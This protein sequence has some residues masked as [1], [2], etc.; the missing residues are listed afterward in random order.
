MHASI[1]EPYPEPPGAGAGTP[2]GPRRRL[3][4][5]TG[6][7]SHGKSPFSG[8]RVQTPPLIHTPAGV[9]AACKTGPTPSKDPARASVT[10]EKSRAR[11]AKGMRGFVFRESRGPAFLAPLSPCQLGGADGHAAQAY[12]PLGP[13]KR[14]K[15]ASRHTHGSGMSFGRNARTLLDSASFAAS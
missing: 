14:Q 7:A 3:A 6:R 15:M 11:G 4:P 1:Q 8:N 12:H 13:E 5:E 9:T 10:H 2:R